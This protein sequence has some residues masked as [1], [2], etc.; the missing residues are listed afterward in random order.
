MSIRVVERIKQNLEIYL[1]I[2]QKK[3]ESSRDFLIL[4]FQNYGKCII[5]LTSY[6]GSRMIKIFKSIY[7]QRSNVQYNLKVYF[8]VR[9]F[10]IFKKNI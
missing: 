4:I 3:K 9:I 8:N 7:Y 2:F 10:L 5:L 1:L 6:Q